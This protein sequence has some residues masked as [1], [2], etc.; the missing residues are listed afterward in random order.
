MN[1]LTDKDPWLSE[2]ATDYEVIEYICC[3]LNLERSTISTEIY[4]EDRYVVQESTIT[5]GSGNGYGGF[6]C[7]FEFDENGNLKDHGV[8]E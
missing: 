3:R 5:I 4:W 2:L 6:Y 7:K 1:S 8:A